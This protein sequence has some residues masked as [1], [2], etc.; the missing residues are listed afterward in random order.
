MEIPNTSA[1]HVNGLHSR[2]P[3]YAC[4]NRDNMTL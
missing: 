4:D 3:A 1:A 2:M